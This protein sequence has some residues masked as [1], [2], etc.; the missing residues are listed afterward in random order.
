MSKIILKSEDLVLITA[1]PGLSGKVLDY[2]IRNRENLKVWEPRRPDSFY[3]KK[4]QK[5]ILKQGVLRAS[6]GSE[7]RFIL[8]EKK[9]II[10]KNS[11]GILSF[12]NIV[13]GPFLSCHVGY[14]IDERLKNRGYM[15]QA[16]KAGIDFIFNTVGLHR[17]EAN[18]MPRNSA[19]VKVVSKLGFMNEGISPKYLKINGEWEDHIHMVLRNR[20]LE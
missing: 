20:S 10:R 5:N 16:L 13:K 12:S 8:F 11:A 1:H 4:Y 2:Y 6:K 9:D 15:T 3:T 19:S 14:S 18:I 7:Y 17:I